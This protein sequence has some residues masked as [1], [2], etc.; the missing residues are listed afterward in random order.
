MFIWIGAIALVLTAAFLLKIGFDRGIITE[1][2]RVIAAGVFGLAMWV[3]GEWS[4]R[5]VPLVAQALCGA[6]VAVLYATV[7]AGH[8]LYGLFGSQG[9]AVAFGIMVLITACAVVLSLRHGVAVAV[10][11]MVG[12]F[13]MPPLLLEGFAGPSAGMVL[14]LIALEVG[15]LAVT[16]RRGWFGISAL[17]L[18]FTFIWAVSYAIFGDD[19][20]DRVLT[21]VLVIGTAVAYVVQTARLHRDPRATTSTRNKLLAMSITAVTGAATL[22]ALLAARGNFMAQDMWML[23]AVAAGVIVL[24]RLDR[25]HLYLPFGVMGLSLFILTTGV[26]A[27]SI[28]DPSIRTTL[29][30]TAI[31]YG[32]LFMLGGYICMWGSTHRRVFALLSV[33]AGPAFFGLLITNNHDELGYRA[34]W[35]PYALA[36]AGAYAAGAVPLLRRRSAEHDWPI[37]AYTMTAFG[38]VCLSVAQGLSHPWVAVHLVI[39]SALAVLID[40]SLF[41]RP[42]Q[43]MAR[44]VAVGAAVLLVIPGPF[45][46]DI[47]GVTVFNT[48]LPMYALPAVGFAVIAWCVHQAGDARAARRLTWLTTGTLGLMLVVLTR[49]ALHPNNFSSVQPSLFESSAYACVLMLAAL[50]GLMIAKRFGLSAVREASA[51][52]VGI[53]AAVG[54][55]GAI[56]TGNPLMHDGIDGGMVLAVQLIGLYLAPAALMWLWASRP[57]MRH[58]NQTPRKLL[59]L[60]ALA[61]VA[62]CVGLQVRN[63]FHPDALNSAPVGMFECVAYAVAWMLLGGALRFIDRLKLGQAAIAPMGNVILGLGLATTL[64]G[65][66]VV[67]NPLWTDATVGTTTVFNGLWLLYAPAIIATALLARAARRCEQFELAKLVGYTTLSVGFLLLSLLV[68]QGFSIDGV[69]LLDSRPAP[70][71]RYAYSLAWVLYGGILLIAGVFTRL[72]TLRYGSLAVLIVA[73]GKVFLIDTASLDNLYRVF[74]F[75][76]LG[77]TLIGLGYLYQRLVFKRPGPSQKG[78]LSA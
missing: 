26:G 22:V 54:L 33:L 74:S 73:V 62:M 24:A 57:V 64:L 5:R 21:A 37:A 69:L 7:L 55:L 1:P 2:V 58:F 4:R 71:E 60:L 53:G 15:I 38:F 31:G 10:L 65:N 72:D 3:V 9:S 27:V 36:I 13:V 49:D 8:T 47:R 41:I 14:Y 77:V 16:G 29:N 28:D 25:K 51:V 39:V 6:A 67:L 52:T 42:L 63:L 19:P 48:L 56:S 23:G 11:G 61:M 12:G 40:R 18:A 70:G 50:P 66:V 44:C 32:L 34:Y 59:R 76:G 78:A 46:V 68:R 43:I 20:A 35:W 17:S 45:W 30:A 75:F